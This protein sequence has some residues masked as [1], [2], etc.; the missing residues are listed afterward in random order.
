MEFKVTRKQ[1]AFMQSE[2]DE[3]LFGGAA[4]GGKSYAQIIDA[5]LFA[6]RHEG[7][8]Q[9]VLRRKM[10]ELRRSL[11]PL[12]LSIFPSELGRYLEGSGQWRFLNGSVIEFGHCN[13]DG[14]VIR[15]QSAEYDVI[16]FDELTHFTKFQFLYLLSRLRGVNGYPKQIKATTNPGGVGHAWVKERF[17]DPSPPNIIFKENERS[18]IFIP[19]LVQDNV[20]LMQS[21]GGYI[22]R[23]EELDSDTKAA[24][25]K[26][27]WNISKGQYFPEFKREIH[28]SKPF[29]IPSSW[30]R[31]MA[32]DYGLD[33][34]ACYW[35]ALD[36]SGRGYIYRELYESGLIISEAAKKMIALEGSEKIFRRLAPPDLFSRRQESGRSA[37]DIFSDEGLYFERSL[38][39]RVFGWYCVK[40]WLKPIT[41]EF[42]KRTARLKIFD[43]CVNLIRTLPA[44]QRDIQNPNDTAI[45]PHELTHAPDA[46]RAFCATMGKEDSAGCY[47]NNAQYDKDIE[48]FLGY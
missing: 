30:R 10:V 20:F 27:D 11:V 18:R 12:S 29:A 38:N 42:G 19:A 14:D 45:N 7:S 43:N 8:R 31:V 33:M 34:L 5:L 4:G 32:I 13:T 3:T 17:I 46:L 16:R 6:L 37:V 23:L 9:L 24:L 41:D 39:D 26:G 48:N 44:L 15:Y 40:E 21:D 36:E 47:V 35:I 25:L 22:K 2:C 28:V 1:L